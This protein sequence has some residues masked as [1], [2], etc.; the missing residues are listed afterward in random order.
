MTV[1]PLNFGDD[2]RSLKSRTTVS[3]ARRAPTADERVETNMGSVQF[4]AQSVEVDLARQHGKGRMHA[5]T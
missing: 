1:K 5:A 4:H 3:P 2:P